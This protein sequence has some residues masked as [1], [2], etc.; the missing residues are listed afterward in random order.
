MGRVHIVHIVAFG[1][2]GVR[3]MTA[4]Q[5]GP[6]VKSPSPPPGNGQGYGGQDNRYMYN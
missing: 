1:N 4:I 2:D 3:R 6:V 5:P